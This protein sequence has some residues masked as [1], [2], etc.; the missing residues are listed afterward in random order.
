MRKEK[1][2]LEY[3][4]ATGSVNTLWTRLSTPDGLAEWFADNVTIDGNIY[5]FYWDN[6]PTEAQLVGTTPLVY[7]RFRW[8]EEEPETYFEFR[9]H[10]DELTGGLVLGITDFA[11]PDEKER[12]VILWETQIKELRRKL[13]I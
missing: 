9:L 8:T 12:A 10:K 4:F 11:E 7:I 3:V 6:Y 13:G 2:T 1:F 5:S